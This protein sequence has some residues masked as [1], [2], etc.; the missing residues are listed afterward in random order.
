MKIH[1]IFTSIF[2]FLMLVMHIWYA[3]RDNGEWPWRSRKFWLAEARIAI[4]FVVIVTVMIVFAGRYKNNSWF[5]ETRTFF[6]CDWGMSFEEVL[7]AESLTGRPSGFVAPPQLKPFGGQFYR[8]HAEKRHLY[9]G[10]Q[11]KGRSPRSY[12]FYDD[13]LMAGCT[14]TNYREPSDKVLE[15]IAHE[16]RKNTIAYGDPVYKKSGDMRVLIWDY[17]D[18]SYRGLIITIDAQQGQVI[19]RNISLDKHLDMATLKVFTDH[20]LTSPDQINIF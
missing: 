19:K 8:M 3:Y 1:I 13:A 14:Y 2:L 7:K 12:F 15:Q 10:N 9:P 17:D 4:I 5:W 6:A 11:Q 16:R 20:F 18:R